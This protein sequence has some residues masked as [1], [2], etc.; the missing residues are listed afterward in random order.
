MSEPNENKQ[1]V[2]GVIAT[3]IG[4][5]AA[6]FVGNFLYN[7]M[8]GVYVPELKPESV[9]GMKVLTP[10]PFSKNKFS[11][12]E[13]SQLDLI[14]EKAVR[15]T[16]DSKGKNIGVM[17][18]KVRYKEGSK[19]DINGAVNGFLQGIRGTIGVT[20]LKHTVKDTMVGKFPAKRLSVSYNSFNLPNFGEITIIMDDKHQIQV[21]ATYLYA[22]DELNAAACKIADNLE[23]EN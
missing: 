20:G 16:S 9:I 15:Y 5:L 13:K 11:A 22:N 3:I 6:A 19:T 2:I 1:N 18:M 14:A 17:V 21:A 4:F 10:G 12:S 8:F 23:F 7:K